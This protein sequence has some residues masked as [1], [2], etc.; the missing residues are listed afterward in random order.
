M[1]LVLV[2]TPQVMIGLLVLQLNC[3]GFVTFAIKYLRPVSSDNGSCKGHLCSECKK[4]CSVRIHQLC[5]GA[6]W[7][8]YTKSVGVS[9][10]WGGGRAAPMN[11]I[12]HYSIF[13][14]V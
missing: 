1:I 12:L 7:L 6:A 4:I 14:H 13:S 8:S 5:L 2:V 11:K 9:D 3:R 10:C